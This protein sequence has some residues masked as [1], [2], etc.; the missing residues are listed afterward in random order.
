[1]NTVRTYHWLFSKY[2]NHFKDSKLEDIKEFGSKEIN[3]YHTILRESNHSSSSMLNQ[4]VNAVK[5]Y[6]TEVL[7]REIQVQSVERPR[8][9]HT[10]P[11]VLSEQEVVSILQS[12]SN[13]KHKVILMLIYAAGLRIGE[14]LR[15]KISDIQSSRKMI[16]IRG[17]KGNKDRFTVLSDK[18]LVL[19]RIYYKKYKPTEYLFEGQ[20]GGAYSEES[21]RSILNIAIERAGIKK[22]VTPHMLRHSFAT[23][24]LEHG[25]D[26]RYIQELL[27]HASSKTTEIYTHVSK[28]EISKIV[29]PAD[30]IGI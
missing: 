26:L 30:F 27:G 29:S 9:V 20:N 7:G 17:A 25:T 13:L 2:L 12:L 21:V 6:Y 8:A 15:L 3:A 19:L 22:R 18:L 28:K 1:M 4:S 5:F 11:K 10:L 24:L 16:Y 14:A 23:H